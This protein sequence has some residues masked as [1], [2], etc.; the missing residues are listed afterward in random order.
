[1]SSVVTSYCNT[2][3]EQKVLIP[4]WLQAALW[5]SDPVILHVQLQHS[6]LNY[7]E[8]EQ[9]PET[10]LHACFLQGG[11]RRSCPELSLWQCNL[12]HLQGR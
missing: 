3:W 11:I 6:H 12:Q 9:L 7:P 1:M 10:R 2:Y 8:L 4:E 5:E